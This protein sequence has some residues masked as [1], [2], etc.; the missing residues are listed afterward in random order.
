ME[1]EDKAKVNILKGVNQKLKMRGIRIAI[2][3]IVTCI[4]IGASAYFMLFVKQTAFNSEAFK[5]VKIEIKMAT[6]NQL[7]DE[8]LPYNHLIFN[9]DDSLMYVNTH[10]HIENNEENKTSTL[11]FYVTQSYMQKK[12]EQNAKK[13]FKKEWMK[14]NPERDWVDVPTQVDIMLNTVTCN[15]DH[16][17]EVAKV[18]YLVYDYDN[19]NQQNFNKAK[20]EAVLLWDK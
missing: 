7:S 17:N 9:S 8:E 14:Y 19:F 18:Y 6:I 3:S 4:L 11:Y 13:K 1:I 12:E 10:F 16:I 20:S 5:D 2:I 15:I